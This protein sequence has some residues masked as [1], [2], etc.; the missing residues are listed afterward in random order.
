MAIPT[1]Q[2]AFDG[3]VHVYPGYDVSKVL[4]CLIGNLEKITQTP[5]AGGDCVYLGLMAES[6]T[7]RFHADICRTGSPFS[8]G[9]FSLVAGP[10]QGCLTILERDTIRGYLIAGRQ[11][12]TAERLE[13]LGLGS[14]VT[15]PDG[16][17]AETTLQAIQAQGATP[18]LSWSPGKWFSSR[19]KLVEKL[20]ETH[21]A[22]DFLI[23][24]TGL[25][26]TF[27]PLPRLMRLASERGYRIIGGSDALPLP[28]EEQWIGTYGVAATAPFDPEKPAGSLR[29]LLKDTSARFTPLGH[30]C[31]PPAFTSRWIRNQFRVKKA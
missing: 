26:P 6:R 30:R 27:W 14:E 16:L 20:I 9:M 15:V 10:D 3:H 12:V 4:T 11:I 21:H 5:Q 28:G 19:G 23:G 24:D 22:G 25:R 1:F 29:R 8:A 17:P 7:C 13:I 18:V 2:I 31:P